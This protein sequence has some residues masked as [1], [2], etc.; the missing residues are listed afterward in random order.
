MIPPEVL[1]RQSLFSLLYKIDQDLAERARARRCPFCGGR[2]HCAHYP[3]KPRGGPPDL[4]EVFEVR[5]SLCCSRDGC[6]RRVLPPS[7]RFWNRRVYWAPVVLLVTALRQGKNPAVTL[8]R[9]KSLCRLWRSTV[10]RWQRYFQDIFPKTD[11][12][13]RLRGRLLPGV[14]SQQLP[15]ALITHFSRSINN[16]ETVLVNCLKTLAL[17]P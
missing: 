3:R 1:H 13:R 11:T 7:V 14:A 16:P 10:K 2:L 4:R 17:G 6:R 12:Y 15:G 9:L 8:Q 5:F